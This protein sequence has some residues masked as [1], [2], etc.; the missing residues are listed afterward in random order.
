MKN[1]FTLIVVLALAAFFYHLYAANKLTTAIERKASKLTTE[2][3]DLSAKMNPFTNVLTIRLSF[4]FA[5]DD[6][7]NSIGV[8]LTDGFI[9]AFGPK[10]AEQELARKAREK[11]D[12]YAMIIPYRVRIV[13]EKGVV[14]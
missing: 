11:Y 8:T 6:M 13:T 12:V 5:N 14:E 1:L 9:Q 7:W 3:M 2:Q 10:K 4:D